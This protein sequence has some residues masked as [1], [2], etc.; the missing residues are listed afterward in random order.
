MLI[1]E[2]KTWID[3]RG[4]GFIKRDDQQPDVFVHVSAITGSLDRLTVGQKVE[5][6]VETDRKSGKPRAAKVRVI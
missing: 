4:F 1:G 6:D 5:F 2:V 3:N